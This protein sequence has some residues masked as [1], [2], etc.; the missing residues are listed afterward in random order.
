M[1]KPDYLDPAYP[2]RRQRR[3]ML[4]HGAGAYVHYEAAQHPS[5]NQRKRRI[6]ARRVGAFT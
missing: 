5:S 1:K 2:N 3:C 4:R 6:R